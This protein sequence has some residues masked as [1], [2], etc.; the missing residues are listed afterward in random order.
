MPNKAVNLSLIA[1]IL[2]LINSSAVGV[3]SVWFPWIFPTLPGSDN[4][5]NVPFAT[6]TIIGL[7]SGV[8]LLIGALMLYG[9]LMSS[10]AI[11]IVIIVFSI[12]SM[13]TGGGF[14]VGFILGIIGGVKA[15]KWKSETKS[16]TN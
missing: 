7:V 13:L 11:G 10:K 9:K 15:L 2:I 5:S 3:A 4:N 12:I 8:L 6:I 14:V 1:G 16:I